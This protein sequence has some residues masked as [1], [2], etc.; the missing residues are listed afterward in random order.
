MVKLIYV[1]TRKAGMAPDE[2][3]HYWRETHAPIAARIPGVRRYV[4]CHV[5][6]A[7]YERAVPPSY[8]GAAELWFDS[9]DALR[10]AMRSPELQAAQEDERN[11]IDHEKVFA[12]TTEEHV[13]VQ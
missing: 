6:L 8:D 2:F 5:P 12:I 9:L 1:I 4:Q 3:Q 13:V 11:F 7:L 10:D